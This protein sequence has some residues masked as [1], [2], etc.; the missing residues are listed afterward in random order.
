[1][2]RLE[3]ERFWLQP[4]WQE[5]T[6]VDESGLW[7]KH[8]QGLIDQLGEDIFWQLILD[9]P[10]GEQAGVRLHCFAFPLC[11]S[12][13]SLCMCEGTRKA[14]FS[15]LLCCKPYCRPLSCPAAAAAV[16]YKV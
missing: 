2:M 16:I 15:H 14:L 8:D 11:I 12:E 6:G 10:V 3:I 7:T 9:A 4:V 1:M 13:K 5:G